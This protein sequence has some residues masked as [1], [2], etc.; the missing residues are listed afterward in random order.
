MWNF[1]KE[2]IRP[3]FK[4]PGDFPSLVKDWQFTFGEVAPEALDTGI[5]STAGVGVALR[6]GDHV[7]LC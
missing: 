4:W 6:N 7:E 2:G 3:H 5:P 1:I